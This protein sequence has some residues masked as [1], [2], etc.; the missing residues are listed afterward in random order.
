MAYPFIIAHILQKVNGK[1][2]DF[3]IAACDVRKKKSELFFFVRYPQQFN[4][5]IENSGIAIC[6]AQKKKQVFSSFAILGSSI[7][8]SSKSPL[9]LKFMLKFYEISVFRTKFRRPPLTKKSLCYNNSMKLFNR[10]LGRT[11]T[12]NAESTNEPENSTNPAESANFGESASKWES[13]QNADSPED[14]DIAVQQEQDRLAEQERQERKLIGAFAEGVNVLNQEDYAPSHEKQEA[15]YRALADGEIDTDA[16][17]RLLQR[18]ATPL[19]RTNKP[20]NVLASIDSKH[21]RRILAYISGVR[22]C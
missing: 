11:E 14:A 8:K 2:F 7:S 9:L 21:E 18:I 5:R 22:A 20:D 4:T 6:V 15:V 12:D 16:K 10:L 1:I 19:Q 17:S 13:L 3:T